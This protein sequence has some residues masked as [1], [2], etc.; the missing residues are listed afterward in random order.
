M[1]ERV[2]GQRPRH[3]VIQH[4]LVRVDTPCRLARADVLEVV[5][6]DARVVRVGEE[7][8]C[9]VAAHGLDELICCR[10]Y[11]G[12]GDVGGVAAVGAQG[13]DE[14]GFI[15]LLPDGAG[16]RLWGPGAGR[17]ALVMRSRG[18]RGS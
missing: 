11:A 5:I 4:P 10:V 18:G 1:R 8:G 13:V 15:A 12:R 3:W 9:I 6:G 7:G 16:R 17:R 14:V 2:D